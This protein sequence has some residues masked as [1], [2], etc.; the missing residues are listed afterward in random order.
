MDLEK[1]NF[2]LNDENDHL[3]LENSALCNLKLSLESN[4]AHLRK[5]L[6]AKEAEVNRL[7]VQSRVIFQSAFRSFF[8]ISIFFK[9]TE[10]KYDQLKID[11][12]LLKES[13]A[14]VQ[15][16]GSVGKRKPSKKIEEK[17]LEIKNL[18][19]RLQNDC[20][21]KVNKPDLTLIVLSNKVCFSKG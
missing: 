8:V 14:G 6:L 10:R 3:K 16:Q 15:E 7:N 9:N 20:K 12:N 17:D 18:I 21:E 4:R 1:S 11:L 13:C 2:H 5:E 19:E